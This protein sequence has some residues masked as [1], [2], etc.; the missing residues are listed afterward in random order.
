MTDC[1]QLSF[2][3]DLQ[4]PSARFA[5]AYRARLS[6]FG[7]LS[8]R[9][10]SRC[11]IVI[12]FFISCFLLFIGMRLS[13]ENVMHTS[14]GAFALSR[15]SHP[16]TRPCT[17]ITRHTHIHTHVHVHI[18]KGVC[19]HARRS[20]G[21]FLRKR[22]NSPARDRAGSRGR[23]PPSLLPPRQAKRAWTRT[24]TSVKIRP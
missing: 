20:L 14:R 1:G 3:P 18:H 22:I 24:E 5:R 13:R 16:V 17:N 11:R 4:L 8:S 2:S 7:R 10:D 12:R 15:A 9:R 23:S 6:R 19:I 21:S